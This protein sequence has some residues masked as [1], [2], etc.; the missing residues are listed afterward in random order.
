MKNWQRKYLLRFITGMAGYSILLPLSLIVVGD[1][2]V[3]QPWLAVLVALLPMAPFLNAM[4][5]V[6]HNVRSQDELF[7]ASS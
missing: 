2:R 5:A 1:G 4:T 6:L 7:G 3:E